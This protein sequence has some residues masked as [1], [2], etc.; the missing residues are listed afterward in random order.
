MINIRH[1]VQRLAILP[2]CSF[3]G[4]PPKFTHPDFNPENL[5]SYQDDIVPLDIE[6]HRDMIPANRP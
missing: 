2:S 3:G 4:H 6:K 1:S 5:S